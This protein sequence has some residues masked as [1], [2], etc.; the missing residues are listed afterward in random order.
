MN[1]LDVLFFKRRFRKVFFKGRSMVWFKVKKQTFSQTFLSNFQQLFGNFFLSKY[2]VTQ[3]LKR[4]YSI[5]VLNVAECLFFTSPSDFRCP[6]KVGPDMGALTLTW[7][8]SRPLLRAAYKVILLHQF[9]EH[10]EKR[11]RYQRNSNPGLDHESSA[12]TARPRFCVFQNI[13]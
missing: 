2:L 7:H 13:F 11:F 8:N 4:Y 6:F 10:S 3:Y 9:I 1:E 5:V 12:L